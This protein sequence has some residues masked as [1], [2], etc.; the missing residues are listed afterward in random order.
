M[1]GSGEIKFPISP[2]WEVLYPE[3]Q[4][5]VLELL[6]EAVTVTKQ[7]VE[8][9]FRTTGIEQILDEIKPMNGQAN[10]KAK[11]HV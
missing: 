6:V 1:V 2:V 4:R 7:E 11:L 8:I 9:R 10:G 3:E 5:R